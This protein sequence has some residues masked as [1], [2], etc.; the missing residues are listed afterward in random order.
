MFRFHYEYFIMSNCVYNAWYWHMLYLGIEPGLFSWE[1][2]TAIRRSVGNEKGFTYGGIVPG[3]MRTLSGAYGC[4][5]TIQYRIWTPEM[6][7]ADIRDGKSNIEYGYFHKAVHFIEDMVSEDAFGDE[8]M[9]ITLR[10][11]VYLLLNQSHAV[12]SEEVSKGGPVM[13]VRVYVVDNASIGSR[14]TRRY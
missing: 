8:V 12:F 14:Y 2:Y 9:R 3:L 13:A 7:L 6:Y 5:V 10:P 1:L 4:S 11:A